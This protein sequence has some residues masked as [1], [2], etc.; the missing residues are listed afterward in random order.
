MIPSKLQDWNYDIIKELSENNMEGDTFDFKCAIKSRD[1]KENGNIIQTACAFA[2]TKGGFIIFGVCRNSKGLYDIKGLERYDNY[3][4]EFGDKIRSINPTVYFVPSSFIIIP[5]TERVLLVIQIPLSQQRPHMTEN[6]NFYYRTN[7]GNEIMQY[8]QV[9]EGFL[10]YEERRQKLELLYMEL[11]S[12]MVMAK[13]LSDQDEN[14]TEKW[15]LGGYDINILSSLIPDVYPLIQHDIDLTK[16][17]FRIRMQMININSEIQVFLHSV[18]EPGANKKLNVFAHNLQLRKLNSEL[19][20]PLL[21]KTIKHLERNYDIITPM[22]DT[23]I[24]IYEDSRKSSSS[25]PSS[26]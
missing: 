16:L 11:V 3:A 1:P 5:H 9:K 26:S 20:Y 7:K 10:N 22:Q 19:L 12:A 14:E 8:Q 15:S 21:K 17:L 6:G 18:H 23:D 25:S 2:N 24:D 13:H 4:K